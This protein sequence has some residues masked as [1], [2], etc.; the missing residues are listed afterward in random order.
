[1]SKYND[2]IYGSGKTYGEASR[3]N[4]SVYPFIATAVD[5][6]S[7]ILTWVRPQPEDAYTA[8][9]IVRSPI[10]YPA[11]VDDGVT[12]YSWTSTAPFLE[13]ITEGDPDNPKSTDASLPLGKFVFY[14]AWVYSS[15]TWSIAGDTSVLIP[16]EH[17]TKIYPSY[18]T[19]D[20][21]KV[22]ANELLVSTHEK[23]L[24]LL[25]RILTSETA[26]TD[27]PDLTSDLS[28]F[29]E[30]FSLTLD[31]VLTYSDII[32]PQNNRAYS[33]A[34]LLDLQ[35]RQVDMTSDTEGFTATQKR[36]VRDSTYIYSRK[37]TSLGLKTLVQDMTTYPT[38]VSTSSN[39]LLSLQD[40]TFYNGIGFWKSSDGTAITAI[41]AA[42]PTA[43]SSDLVV[44][45]EWVGQIDTTASAG[46]LSI[47]LG[48][49]TP[50]L[51]GIPVDE[52]LLYTLTYQVKR[53]SVSKTVSGTIS[54]YDRNGLI[55]GTTAISS[56]TPTTS[57]TAKSTAL[58][59]LPAGTEF[60]SI[61]FN[62]QNGTVYY[63]D[64]IQ[65][66]LTSVTSYSESRA[67]IIT[68]AQVNGSYPNR[69]P[70]LARL[71]TEINTYLP[72][73]KA[74]FILDSNGLVSFGVSS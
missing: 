52:K 67:A 28:L 46:A 47:F 64:R 49:E 59:T 22:I 71:E 48:K 24:S 40:S 58:G 72:V 56:Y 18:L 5:Y 65:L 57:W 55:L 35:R 70:R 32:I 60:V 63:F 37:G 53:G 17:S 1:M 15:G 45:T 27:A 33:N 11:T 39:L 41:K 36:L 14:R 50:I 51:T 20:G 61:E 69:N 23:V 42:V 21:K 9:K 7:V 68:L 30:G 13:T 66:A 2:I 3:A 4:N 16:E 6:T 43:G 38:T 12:V 34:P 10:A 74:F 44:D 8:F 62:L 29:L 25:P 31:E 26:A 73:N 54:F 19:T